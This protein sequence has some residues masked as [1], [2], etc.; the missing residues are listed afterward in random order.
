MTQIYIKQNI[1]KHRT[2]NLRY[3]P[4]YKEEERENVSVYRTKT[5]E[6]S[7]VLLLCRGDGG[8]PTKSTKMSTMDSTLQMSSD[9]EN[10][11]INTNMQLNYSTISG[12]TYQLNAHTQTHTKLTVNR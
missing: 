11:E 8:V 5:E 3:H 4:F 12:Q 7:L 6:K 1:H 2:Q 9:P 10:A